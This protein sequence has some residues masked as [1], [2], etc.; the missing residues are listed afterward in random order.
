MMLVPVKEKGV[1]L[2]VGQGVEVLERGE[3]HYIKT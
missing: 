3:H 2:Q 1:K